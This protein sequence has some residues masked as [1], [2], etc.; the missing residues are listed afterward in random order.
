M[1]AGLG[2][3]AYPDCWSWSCREACSQ[4][5]DVVAPPILEHHSALLQVCR[6][7]LHLLCCTL[8]LTKTVD[9]APNL[10]ICAHTARLKCKLPSTKASWSSVTE[11]LPLL[12]VSTAANHCSH[13]TGSQGSGFGTRSS[14]AHVVPRCED[15]RKHCCSTSST[16]CICALLDISLGPGP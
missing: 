8:W 6:Q 16:C 4:D 1:Y 9:Y 10:I 13:N 11:I 15:D 12:S 2:S 5:V 7:P 14:F 3:L